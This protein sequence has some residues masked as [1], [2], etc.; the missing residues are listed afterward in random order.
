MKIKKALFIGF[1]DKKNYLNDNCPICQ[2]NIFLRCGVCLETTNICPTIIG[3]CKH[4]Y[5]KHCMNKWLEQSNKCPI[6]NLKFE[7]K[8]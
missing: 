3:Q 4:I 1:S 5:H 8:N 2:E 7:S 6:D